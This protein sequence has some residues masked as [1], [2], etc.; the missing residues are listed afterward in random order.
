MHIQIDNC[1]DNVHFM[2]GALNGMLSYIVRDKACVDTH[3][4]YTVL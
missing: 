3:K 1:E 4:M 2:V